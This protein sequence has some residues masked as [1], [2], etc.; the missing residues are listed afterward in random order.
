MK[1]ADKV[2]IVT[3][4]ASGIGR[5]LCRRFAQEGAKAVVVADMNE[6]GTKAVADEIQGMPVTCDVRREDDIISMVRLTEKDIG[7]V[8]LFCSNAGILTMGGFEVPDE[9]WQRIWEINVMSHVYAARA[10]FPGIGQVDHDSGSHGSSPCVEWEKK[11][12]EKTAAFRTDVGDGCATLARKCR[13]AR[14]SHSAWSARR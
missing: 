11:R 3:G 2:V 8:D 7:P 6:E 14:A 4:G 13:M 9:S 10:V 5:A 1:V 12:E